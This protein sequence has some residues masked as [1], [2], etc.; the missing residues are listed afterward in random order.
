V[1]DQPQADQREEEGGL[2][3]TSPASQ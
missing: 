1:P 2:I 3:Q